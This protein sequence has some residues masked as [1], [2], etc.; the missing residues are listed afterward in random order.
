MPP[1]HY[2]PRHQHPWHQLLYAVSGVLIADVTGERLFIPPE[3]AVWLPAGTRH[4]VSSH[5]G[6]ELKSLYIDCRYDQL[7]DKNQVL[8]MSPLIKA[9]IS[10]AAEFPAQ[11]QQQGYENQ[12]MA[13][14]LA[15]LPRLQQDHQRLPWPDNPQFHRLCQY[16]YDHPAD[17]RTTAELAATLNLS[18]RTLERRF[19]QATGIGLQHWRRQL[20]LHKAIELLNAGRSVTHIAFEL[21]YNSASSFIYMFRQQTGLSPNRFQTNRTHSVDSSDD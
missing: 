18:K 11:Y 8:L 3:K 17:R 19:K 2:F 20:R 16:L 5:Y 12:V 7:P 9:L 13:M 10:E 14:I 4:E 15:V 6:A 1:G 21:G